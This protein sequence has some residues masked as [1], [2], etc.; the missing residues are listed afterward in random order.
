MLTAAIGHYFS[1]RYETGDKSHAGSKAET[2]MQTQII[3]P[4]VR[5]SQ[6]SLAIAPLQRES[7]LLGILFH[8]LL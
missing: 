2:F 3:C 6:I 5:R 4:A 8:A 1:K 7:A